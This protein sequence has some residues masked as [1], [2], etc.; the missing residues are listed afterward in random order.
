MAWVP[1]F[2]VAAAILA[3]QVGRKMGGV[4]EHG[5]LGSTHSFVMMP[6]GD[7]GG[8]KFSLMIISIVFFNL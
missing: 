2:E 1:H 7:W 5:F 6:K 3:L 4:L 8:E